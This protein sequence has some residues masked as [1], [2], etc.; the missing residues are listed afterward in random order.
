[1]RKVPRDPGELAVV[2]HQLEDP[3][4]GD[5]AVVSTE[6]D[7]ARRVPAD[8]EPGAQRT[9][10]LVV[11]RKRRAAGMLQPVHEQRGLAIVVP[12]C[13]FATHPVNRISCAV[14]WNARPNAASSDRRFG[15]RM[16]PYGSA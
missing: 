13:L 6:E 14:D 5:A 3:N 2:A 1:M 10:L 11:H 4:P 8:L 12:A 7:R 15:P 16:L 9:Q